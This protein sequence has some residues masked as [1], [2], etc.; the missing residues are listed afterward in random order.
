M[1][2]LKN[3]ARVSL[4]LKIQLDMFALVAVLIP[5]LQ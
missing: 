3:V 1:V 4:P 2:P 5:H